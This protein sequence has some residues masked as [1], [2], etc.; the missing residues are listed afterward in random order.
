MD[1]TIVLVARY[2]LCEVHAEGKEKIDFPR[3]VAV[4]DAMFWGSKR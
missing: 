4:V 2:V 3:K 1:S